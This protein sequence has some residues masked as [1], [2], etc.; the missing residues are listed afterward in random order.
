VNSGDVILGTMVY[1]GNQ[2]WSIITFDQK[3]K[4]STTLN[5]NVGVDELYAFVSLEVYN[6]ATCKDYPNGV[7]PY[8]GLS[9]KTKNKNVT[10]K[11]QKDVTKACNE[12]VTI[13]SPT[14]VTIKF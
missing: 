12:A 4:V 11:W 2:T 13:N 14:S 10:P 7:V 1:N 6:V 3:T 8:T 5:V 9:L